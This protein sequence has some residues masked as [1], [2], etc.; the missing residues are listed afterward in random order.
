[1]QITP[2]AA[3]L[4]GAALLTAACSMTRD[5]ARAGAALDADAVVGA[6]WILEDMAGTGVIDTARSTLTLGAD[7]KVTGQGACNRFGGPYELDGAAL[8]VGPLMS[9]R[10]AC[11]PVVMDQERRFLAL[12]EQGGTLRLDGEGL[13]HFTA[14]SDETLRFAPAG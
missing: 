3:A 2:L 4:A 1:M 9:T 13:M 10:M 5:E 7:G 8:S 11:P 14:P 6:E 12:L